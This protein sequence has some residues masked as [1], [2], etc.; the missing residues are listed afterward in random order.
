MS[1]PSKKTERSK[2][3]IKEAMLR[4][5]Y[6][7][8]F[9]S[10]T[11]NQLLIAANISR[12]TFYTHFENL[13]DVRQHIINDLFAS[14][15]DTFKGCTA[16]GLANDPRPVVELAERLKSRGPDSA[17]QLSKYLNIPEIGVNLT[18]WL[19]DFILSDTELMNAV[20]DK[21]SSKILARF[22]AGGVMNAF[23][24]W[25]ANDF[26]DDPKEFFDEVFLLLRSGIAGTLK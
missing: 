25:V 15:D 14:A 16:S 1:N 5:L 23:N 26:D 24:L 4:L 13:S 3:K 10:I 8:D 6:E 18:I 12:G 17:K 11:V 7:K 2:Q 9:N 22:A 19:T 20:D 21:R